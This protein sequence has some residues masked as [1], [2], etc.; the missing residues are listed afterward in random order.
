MGLG[1]NF[2]GSL[3]PLFQLR[4]PEQG[5]V[6]AKPYQQVQFIPQLSSLMTAWTKTF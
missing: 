1:V 3:I 2:T 4:E 5:K 6:G